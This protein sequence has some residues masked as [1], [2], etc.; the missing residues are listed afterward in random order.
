MGMEEWHE[1]GMQLIKEK[2]RQAM[3][4]LRQKVPSFKKEARNFLFY[5]FYYRDRF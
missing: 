4:T 2:A 3:L 1:N 5:Y